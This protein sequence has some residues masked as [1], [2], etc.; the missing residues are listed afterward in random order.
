MER[1]VNYTHDLS[2]IVWFGFSIIFLSILTIQ[3]VIYLN[4]FNNPLFTIEI[5]NDV[6]N[7]EQIEEVEENCEF[8]INSHDILGNPLNSYHKILIT[9]PHIPLYHPVDTP[10]PEA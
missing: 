4:D 5:T 10:P 1:E 8:Y 2:R 3:A 9:T 6:E 7:Q